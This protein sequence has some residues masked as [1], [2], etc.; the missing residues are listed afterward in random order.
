M[1]ASQKG[2]WRICRNAESKKVFSL[3]DPKQGE[4]LV[5]LGCGA[6]YYAIPLSSDFGLKVLGVDSSPS[7]LKS[8]REAGIATHLSSIESFDGVGQFDKALIAGVLEFIA[9]PELALENCSKLIR[10]G[11]RLVI[12]VPG[13]GVFSAAYKLFHE[14]QNCPVYLRPVTEYKRIAKSHGFSPIDASRCTP[15]SIAMSFIKSLSADA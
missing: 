7:M 6:G 2:L 11:G 8:V 15:F 10:D 1:Q 12:L 14:I 9:H 5:D 3:L 4:S 13:T